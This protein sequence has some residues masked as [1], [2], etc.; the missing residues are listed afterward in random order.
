[1]K[2][3][4]NA[5]FF[6]ARWTANY[7]VTAA[8]AASEA[9]WAAFLAWC[10]AFLAALVALAEASEAA[11]AASAAKAPTANIEATRAAISFFMKNSKGFE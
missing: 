4:G 9:L 5:G 1:M 10:L 7:L 6:H 2:K 3:P 8:E 11:G